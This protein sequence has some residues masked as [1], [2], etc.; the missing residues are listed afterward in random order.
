MGHKLLLFLFVDSPCNDPSCGCVFF[1]SFF[2][3]LVCRADFGLW[4][5]YSKD[6]IH[7]WWLLFHLPP[8]VALFISSCELQK[9]TITEK[10]NK[11][12]TCNNNL[13]RPAQIF[14]HVCVYTCGLIYSLIFAFVA[15]LT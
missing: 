7:V 12:K 1:F 6:V 8:K 3:L 4:Q 14:I 5:L 13:V 9:V 10:K 11:K 2:F 15:V